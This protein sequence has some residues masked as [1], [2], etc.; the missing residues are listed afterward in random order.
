[1]SHLLALLAALPLALSHDVGGPL[2]L[3][4]L[5]PLMLLAKHVDRPFSHGFACGFFEVFLTMWGASGYG[6][7]IPLT[8]ALQAGVARGAL[9]WAV[10]RGQGPLMPVCVLVLG[11]GL[12]A[13][14]VLSLPLST[15]HDLATV[16]WLAWPAA[17]GGGALLT[18]ICGL[19]AY[20]LTHVDRRR[21][22]GLV[23]VGLLGVAGLHEVLRPA[24]GD[25]IAL[26]ASVI[27]GGLPNWVYRQSAVD[28]R[29]K[30][31]IDQ[32]YLTVGAAQPPGRLLIFP[33]TAVR[34]TFGH[35]PMSAAYRA[36]HAKGQSLIAGVNR[37][38]EGA[39][40]NTAMVWSRQ[41]AEPTFQSKRALVPIVER[42]FESLNDPPAILP[43]EGRVQL[44]IESVYPRFSRG[45]AARWLLVLTNDAGVGR[46]A[47]RR[48][49]ERESRL[50]AIEMGR[51]LIRAGQDG[52][53][54][55]LSW[56]GEILAELPE[57][58]PGVL[59]I[60]TLPGP[61]DTLRNWAGD[62]VFW[63]CWPLAL[64]GFRRRTSVGA[65]AG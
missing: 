9:A 35:G 64:I 30:Q 36:M 4:A 45:L 60:E 10:R 5:A 47:P 39:L 41:A 49:F 42:E 29:A 58:R 65:A 32:A 16:P 40:R 54:Y 34:D 38:F 48:A 26:R 25:P 61:S 22:V 43:E 17:F 1:M 24:A 7:L 46:S 53:T 23:L 3:V 18:A 28:R 37:H 63:L 27:Q 13:S 19:C 33:E 31:A 59:H 51:S 62:W 20:A 8:L 52:R 15:G 11:Q 2:G 55:A 14:S 44:C 56:R 21:S 12:R 57:Y 6:F 50:R